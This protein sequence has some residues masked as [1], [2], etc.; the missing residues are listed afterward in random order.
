MTNGPSLF[1]APHPGVGEAV[2]PAGNATSPGPD[3]VSLMRGSHKL[4]VRG[5]AA[6]AGLSCL[7][8]MV[9]GGGAGGKG[10]GQPCCPLG[11]HLKY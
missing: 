5:S 11:A 8:T 2:V 3:T 4:H 9:W 1:R 6:A 7:S 10:G